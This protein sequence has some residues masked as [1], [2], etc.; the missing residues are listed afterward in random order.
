MKEEDPQ[1]ELDCNPSGESGGAR[2]PRSIFAAAES[3]DL[4][5][6]STLLADGA[7]AYVAN[8]KEPHRNSSAAAVSLPQLREHL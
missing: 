5:S 8:S 2:L 3:G 1:L 4:D 7:D 6:V